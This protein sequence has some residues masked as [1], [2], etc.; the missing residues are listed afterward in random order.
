MGF[1]NAVAI[2]RIIAVMIPGCAAA[3]RKVKQARENNSYTDMT[4]GRSLKC[5]LLLDD[6][7]VIGCGLTHKTILAR[8]DQRMNPDDD[9]SDEEPDE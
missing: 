2:W 9:L 8:L 5:V 1:G 4:F 3:R 7:S 6:G